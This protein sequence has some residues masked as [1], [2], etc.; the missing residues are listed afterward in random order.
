MR[1]IRLRKKGDLVYLD[2]TYAL[3]SKVRTKPYTHISAHR[4]AEWLHSTY[5]R[6]RYVLLSRDCNCGL[7]QV[8]LPA[9]SRWPHKFLLPSLVLTQKFHSDGG[10]SLVSGAVTGLLT[11]RTLT[12]EWDEILS[13][14]HDLLKLTLQHN[15]ALGRLTY[16][17]GFLLNPASAV[18]QYESAA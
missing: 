15:T 18:L 3:S 4:K 11:I 14:H 16:E 7:P 2:I 6:G 1:Q 5:G 9:M 17:S 12:Y 10:C 13:I 8:Q